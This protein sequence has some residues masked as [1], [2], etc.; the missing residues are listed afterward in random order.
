MFHAD[1]P[2]AVAQQR[3]E[4]QRR[5][6]EEFTAEADELADVD[7]AGAEDAVRQRL[8]AIDSIRVDRRVHRPGK[9]RN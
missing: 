5:L 9:A 2:Y 3:G 6:L 1:I 7:I 4:I 8:D